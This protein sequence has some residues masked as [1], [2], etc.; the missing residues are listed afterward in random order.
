MYVY[1]YIY[2][3]IPSL[4]KFML[5]QDSN[6]THSWF[7]SCDKN[8][9]AQLLLWFSRWWIQFGSITEIFSGPLAGSFKYFTSAYK[10]NSHG[11]KFLATLH[12]FVKKYEVP[13]ILK[14]QYVKEG[15]VLTQQW[16]VKWW[17]K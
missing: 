10:T 11:E 6:M 12:H 1:I 17:D 16:F 13:W 9:D 2:I 7:V 5:H 8:F 15:D 4:F 14:W 3:Y